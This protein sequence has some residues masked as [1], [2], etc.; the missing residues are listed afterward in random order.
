MKVVFMYAGQGSQFYGMGKDIY[1]DNEIFR[2]YADE[3][4]GIVKK[5]LGFTINDIVFD[6]TKKRSTA[7]MEQLESSLSILWFEYSMTKLLIERGVQPDYLVGCSLGEFVSGIIAGAYKIEDIIDFAIENNKI[8]QAKVRQGGMLAIFTEVSILEDRKELFEE[9]EVV[10]INHERHC[11]IAGST[12]RIE[13]IANRLKEEKILFQKLA[14]KYPFHSFEMDRAKQDF[15]ENFEKVRSRDPRIEMISCADGMPVN[16]I[17]KEYFWR[18]LRNP[19]QFEK[20]IR[21][22]EH[23]PCVY[24]D[25]SASGELAGVSKYLVKK[26]EN[27][28]QI[29]SIFARKIDIDKIIKSIQQKMDVSKA[30]VFPGQGSQKKG[31]GAGLFAEF[32]EITKTADRVLGYSIRELCEEDPNSLLNNTQYTQPALFVVSVLHYLKA[33]K[34]GKPK[35]AYVIGHSIGEYVALFVAGAFDFETGM[36]LVKKRAELMSRTKGGMAAVIGLNEEQVLGVIRNNGLTDID[37]ANINTH[38]QIVIAGERDRIEKIE[39]L[40]KACE[41]CRKYVVLKT[42]GAFHSRYMRPIK[43]EFEAFLGGF[44]FNKLEIPVIANL[45]ARPYRQDKIAETLSEHLVNP[46]KWMDCVRYVMGKGITSFE[47]I[48]GG[49]VAIGMVAVIRRNCTPLIIADEEIEKIIPSNQIKSRDKENNS[50]ENTKTTINSQTVAVMQKSGNKIW[51]NSFT[52]EYNSKYPLYIGG[53]YR[54]ISGT[55]LVSRACNS[56]YLAFFG[57]GGLRQPDIKKAITEIKMNVGTDKTFG[58]NIPYSIKQPNKVS[59]LVDLLLQEQVTVLEAASFIEATKDLVRYRVKGLSEKNGQIIAKNRVIAKLSRPEVAKSFV[60]PPK[61]AVLDELLNEGEITSYEA[62]LALKIPVASDICVEGDSGGHTD[63]ANLLSIFPAIRGIV[64]DANRDFGY[65]QPIRVGAAGGIGSPTSAACVF[66]L[67]ADFIVTGSINQC[68]V[69]AATSNLAKELLSHADIQ[70]TD[71]ISA[72]ETPNSSS[73]VQVL[74]KGTMLPMRIK[75]LISLFDKYGSFEEM[76]SAEI[77]KLEKNVFKNEISQIV[78][79]IE[80]YRSADVMRSMNQRQKM[81]SVINWFIHMTTEWAVVGNENQK[82]N[83]QIPCGASMGT[84]NRW[85]SNTKYADWKLR[86][87]DEI[88]DLLMEA[89]EKIFC[90]LYTK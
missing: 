43:D 31:M 81:L 18:I 52:R 42:S 90:E 45:T 26:T 27:I 74:K 40:F 21:Y 64:D 88:N 78:R 1:Q 39:P 34:N 22:L 5:K 55:K 9:C 70:D 53:M 75:K 83:F 25:L 7:F 54:G 35:P 49:D 47:Q 50:G 80:S 89:T 73:C 3:F 62:E 66:M 51:P 76:D 28:I 59:V 16:K 13:E 44:E 63:R 19:I 69:E 86:H 84:F 15:L 36:R 57:A 4:S 20:S 2:K 12:Q 38:N 23:Q 24:V 30:Y 46:V 77:Q 10:S 29:S 79:E 8:L 82:A 17:D 60:N 48:D 41:G 33:L 85:V 32:P 71:Y 65:A 56:G 11:V 14:V 37:I 67:G 6:P 58:V 61:K 72:V 87:V 68:T